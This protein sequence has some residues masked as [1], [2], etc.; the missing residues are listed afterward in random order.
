MVVI[1]AGSCGTL[2]G[3]A[4]KVKEKIPG[5]KVRG[6]KS[7]VQWNFVAPGKFLYSIPLHSDHV[8]SS[9]MLHSSSS[10][11]LPP[12]S[13]S[14]SSHLTS[15]SSSSSHFFLLFLL[16][17]LLLLLLSP[18]PPP[19]SPPLKV[20]AVDPMGSILGRPEEINETTCTGYAVS[21][22]VTYTYTDYISKLDD[23]P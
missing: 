1:G 19:H 5:V 18:L 8:S 17:L 16:L 7:R 10:Y 23:F 22:S 12:R 9:S 21:Q 11:H 4:R 15:S 2:S 6:T 20:V 13:S 3:V 14:S